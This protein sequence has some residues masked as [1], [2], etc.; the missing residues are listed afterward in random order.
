MADI[1]QIRRGTAAQWTS[2]NPILADGELGFETDT[3][4]GKLGNG[5]T[6]WTG[7]TYSFTGNVPD[8]V[9]VQIEAATAKTTPVD[10]D[11]IGITDSAASFVL[12]KVTWLNIKN[13]LKTYFDT[14]YTTASSVLSVVL[15]GISFASSATITA[16]DTI[17]SAFGKLQ[18]QSTI[19]NAKI[20]FDSTSST[21]LA[22]TSGTNTGDETVTTI[23]TL[24]NGSTDKATPVDADLVAIRN[25]TGGLLAK[26]TWLNIKATLKTYFDT[27]Y[28]YLGVPQNSQ[29]VAYTLVLTDAGKHILHP[30]ADTTARIFTIP[31]NA[32]VVFPIGTAITFVNQNGAGVITISITTDT[33]RLAG[34]GTTGSRTLA[35][36]GVATALK[37]TSTEWIISGS[38]LT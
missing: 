19:N 17:L 37:L 6:A 24:I 23:G 4:K 2:T 29:S 11:N 12:K 26:V 3:K 31:A 8:T 18:A 36:N 28:G 7:L 16:T 10:A 22:N 1:L 30:S 35:A 38:N 32:S 5:V 13:T 20:S 33:M 9:A 14:L 21:R 15:T 25:T 34:A 27:L